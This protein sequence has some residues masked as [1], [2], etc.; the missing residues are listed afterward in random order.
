MGMVRLEEK[1]DRMVS[2]YLEGSFMEDSMDLL[3][4]SS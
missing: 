3:S 1:E 4:L 2:S